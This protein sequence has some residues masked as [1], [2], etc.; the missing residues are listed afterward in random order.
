MNTNWLLPRE[1]NADD[2]LPLDARAALAGM[3]RRMLVERLRN[4]RCYCESPVEVIKFDL[5]HG[6]VPESVLMK[7]CC[8]RQICRV[9]GWYPRSVSPD[10][11]WSVCSRRGR[12]LSAHH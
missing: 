10:A 6:T 1:P 3:R 12:L 5:E 11:W 4:P 9:R 7:R 2:L 8:W